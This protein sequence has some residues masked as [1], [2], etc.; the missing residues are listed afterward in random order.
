MVKVQMPY[1]NVPQF[2]LERWTFAEAMQ[3][4]FI[5]S[6]KIQTYMED[7]MTKDLRFLR[8]RVATYVG[9]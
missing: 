7:C 3:D 5:W 1:F 2:L 9:R 8:E 6:G 4:F